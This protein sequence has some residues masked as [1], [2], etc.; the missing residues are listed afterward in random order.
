[1]TFKEAFGDAR[2]V[3]P[4]ADCQCPYLRREFALSGPVE[5]ADIAI[6][7]LGWFEL[8]INGERASGELFAPVSS[9]YCRREFTVCGQPFKEELRHRTYFA[10][11]DV[12]ELV[13]PGAN[14]LGVALAPGWFGQPTWCDDG[15]TTRFGDV[16]L[17]FRLSVR[18]A[19]GEE[20]QFTSSPDEV[21][22]ASGPV[23]KY[24]LFT[25]ET[26]DLRL[27]RDGW[28]EPG[29][30]ADEFRPTRELADIDTCYQA[31]DCPADA[32]MR[33][34]RPRLVAQ[35]G[36]VSVYDVGEN[37]SGTPVLRA[38]GAAGDQ[39]VLR[40]AEELKGGCALDENYTHGQQARFI[41][42]GRPRELSAR[43][44]WF[45]FRYFSV[46][47][48]AEAVDCLVIHSNIAVTA[49]FDSDSPALNWLFDAYIR[50]QLANMHS[51]IPSDCP[52]IER[53]GYTG[54]GQLTCQSA[55]LTLDAR[56]FY[57]KWL[58]DIED[59]Q[60]DLTGH[61]QY[62][63]PYTRCGGGPGG[64][65]CAIVH[66]PYCYYL[67]Y[68]DAEPMRRMLPRMFKY[69]NYLEAHSEDGLVISDNPGQWCLGDW[70]T[71]G[72][73]EIPAPLV[74]NYFYIK[75]MRE[76]LA[77]CEA[78]GEH[79]RDAELKQR[80]AERSD[81]LMRRYFDPAT[82][83]FAGNAQGANAFMV[84]IGLGDER[85]LGN[86]VEGYTR[87]GCLDTGI[88][89]TDIVP[90]VLF[91]RGYDALAYALLASDRE[92]SFDRFR[93]LGATTLW[94]YWPL[95]G[96]RSHS[97]PMFGG[98]VRYLFEYLL[99]I[100]QRGA[101]WERPV[102]SPH[103][104]GG[105]SRARGSILTPNGRI[106]VRIDRAG[107]KWAIDVDIEDARGGEFVLN[108]VRRPLGQGATHIAVEAT[109]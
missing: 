1:M 94:E 60:D 88:F 91:E 84:D 75:S 90:R 47:G 17:A 81:A 55:M 34:I 89:G 33:R 25:G 102:I 106:A 50:T 43:F 70:C 41:L 107:G 77:I 13:R 2:W 80:I 62:T 109:A 56:A 66:V 9:D 36:A 100:G 4:D 72:E 35:Q 61:V 59:C 46:E 30:A 67:Q 103:L 48:P 3:G 20:L 79:A 6:C 24:D 69:F 93:Q 39:V 42:D 53:R 32:V 57:R 7:G 58:R 97:H 83:D 8:Y 23:V 37:I 78:L 22:W 11:Y 16:R 26:H 64:W 63:A 31:Q 92:V 45:G 52:H 96:E 15:R 18:M 74:N 21:R 28:L 10:K 73:I 95:G 27:S 38:A 54:D 71:P 98:P 105:L 65:G 82:G 5:S 108:G 49:E 99:G 76:V 86:M 44:T 40:L 14:A 68:G 104:T 19:D 29:Y 12:T 85:T 101:G 87:A 51:G